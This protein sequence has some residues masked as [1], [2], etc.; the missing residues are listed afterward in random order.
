M[1]WLELL[2][3]ISEGLENAPTTIALSVYVIDV[4][5]YHSTVW[6]SPYNA[7]IIYDVICVPQHMPVGV[8]Y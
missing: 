5:F 1:R 2:P 6:R 7:V 8:C 4:I 3:A